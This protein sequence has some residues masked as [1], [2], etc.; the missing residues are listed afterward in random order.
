MRLEAPLNSVN[1]HRKPLTMHQTSCGERD[2]ALETGMADGVA[3]GYDRL[4]EI[5]ASAPPRK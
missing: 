2:A 4:D 3:V 5:L 1:T